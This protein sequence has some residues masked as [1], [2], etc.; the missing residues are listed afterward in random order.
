MSRPTFIAGAYLR[1]PNPRVQRTR[2]SPSALR[3]PLMRR[4]LGV[5]RVPQLSG[6][7]WPSHRLP[8]LTK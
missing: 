4:L 7:C 6:V 2:S 5:A 8:L 1:R 3:S